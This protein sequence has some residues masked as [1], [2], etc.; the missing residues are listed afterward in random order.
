MN[1][2]KTLLV[3]FILLLAI[4]SCASAKTVDVGTG[5]TYSTISAGM[6][7]ASS[8]D[9][10]HIHAGTYTISNSVILKSGVTVYGDGYNTTTVQASGKSSFANEANPAHFYG[11]GVSNVNIYGIKFKGPASSIS[12]IHDEGQTY[13]GGHDEYH[14]AVKLYNCN[15]IRIHDCYATLLL[16]DFVRCSGSSYIYIYNNVINTCGHDGAQLFNSRNLLFTNNYVNIMINCGVR[17]SGCTNGTASYNTF[18]NALSGSGWCCVQ[19]Q[20]STSGVTVTK[21]VF[22]RTSDNYPCA[23]YSYAGSGSTITNNIGYVIPSSFL[24]NLGSATASNNLVYTTQYDWASW[25]YGYNAAST[26]GGGRDTSVAY[27]GSTPSTTSPSSGSST[28]P[29]DNKTVVS[30]EDVGSSSY[31]VIVSNDSS[32]TNKICNVTTS[33]TACSVPTSD[34]TTYYWKVAGCY[35]NGTCATYTSV[36]NFNTTTSVAGASGVYGLVYTSVLKTPIDGAVVTLSNDT[37]SEMYVTHDDGYYQFTVP[38]SSDV[39]YLTATATD[40]TAPTYQLPLNASEYTSKDIAMAKAPTYFAPHLVKFIVTDSYLLNRYSGADVSIFIGNGG[41][42]L[43]TGETGGDGAIAF[44]L[45]ED[46][47]YRV[48]VEYNNIT[49]TEYLTPFSSTYYILINTAEKTLVNEQFY[50]NVTLNVTKSEIDST[51]AYINA[52]YL[53]TANQTTDVTFLL[54]YTEENGTFVELNNS[55]VITGSNSNYSFIVNNYLGKDYIVKF[56]ITHTVFGDVTKAFAVPFSGN[57]SPFADSKEL[58]YLGIF[59]LFIVALQFGKQEHA[60]GAILLCAIAWFMIYIGMFE[61]LGKTLSDIIFAG[62]I[63]ATVYAVISYINSTR[64]GVY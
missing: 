39:Y 64:E 31:N 34:N 43:Y 57:N 7:A 50:T 46:V 56:E 12:D 16:S 44:E 8:G 62:T 26:S 53:D 35:D 24:Y 21:N 40:Y 51:N 13:Y 17:F 2:S 14:A 25:G 1:F 60:S 38:T 27:T 33:G 19:L 59:I 29:V 11:S 41:T 20:G 37:W 49:T 6:A 45:E 47:Q 58:A 30:W 15:N 61:P 9:S 32:C 5:Y 55:S 28:A 54:G 63:A 52:S 10:V 48:Q 42:A 4:A 23:G 3:S 18:T 36:Q 22:T